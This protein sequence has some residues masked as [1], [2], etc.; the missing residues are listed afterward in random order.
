M[1]E[2]NKNLYLTLKEAG[3]FYWV[4]GSY[5]SSNNNYTLRKCNTMI[6]H[7]EDFLAEIPAEE[8]ADRQRTQQ[9]LEIVKKEREVILERR[10]K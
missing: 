8:E 1:K 9:A 4:L 2:I 6:R 3:L 7:L 5:I 10:K